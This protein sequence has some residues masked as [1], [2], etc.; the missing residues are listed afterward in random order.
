M[1]GIHG[2]MLNFPD[3]LVMLAEGLKILPLLAS[4]I[5]L[6]GLFKCLEEAF[7]FVHC[8]SF[9]RGN[10]RGRSAS[11]WIKLVY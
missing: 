10:E 6:V 2:T 3:Q 7:R 5:S 8:V 4:I 9:A 11:K 1:A